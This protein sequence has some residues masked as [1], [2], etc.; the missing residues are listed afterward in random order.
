VLIAVSLSVAD[1]GLQFV[2]TEVDVATGSEQL[3]RRVHDAVVSVSVGGS[4][5]SEKLASRVRVCGGECES[6]WIRTYSQT[7]C[8]SVAVSASVGEFE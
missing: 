2:M 3:P 6:G 8:M 7:V 4:A 5:E 1:P